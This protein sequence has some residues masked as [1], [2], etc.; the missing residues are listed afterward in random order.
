M[1]DCI[2]DLF[3]KYQT[4]IV[5]ILGFCGVIYTIKMNAK[6]VKKQH[7]RELN[8]ESETIRTVLVAELNGVRELSIPN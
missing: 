1:M 4:F 3:A 2:I 7:E 5:G 8:I 6:S